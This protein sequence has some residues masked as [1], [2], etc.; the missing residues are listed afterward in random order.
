MSSVRTGFKTNGRF[1]ANFSPCRGQIHPNGPSRIS[2]SDRPTHPDGELPRRAHYPQ[3]VRC[4]SAEIPTLAVMQAITLPHFGDPDALAWTTTPDP[5]PGPGEVAV[6][7]AAAGINR[8]DLLQRQGRYPPPPGAS[9]ILGLECSGWV[10]EV[11]PG[12][13]GWSIGDEVCALLSGGGYAERVV[14]PAGQ[15][16]P[17]PSGLSL[18]EAASLP[19]AACTVWSTVFAAAQLAAGETFLV[20]GGTSGIG[21]FA[22]QLARARGVR[23]FTTAGTADKC[24]RAR[25]LGA[26]LAINYRDDDFVRR[27][28]EHTDGRGVDVILDMVGGDYLAR[29]LE[30]LAPDG[31]LVLI[32]TQRGRRA[33]LD[34]GALMRKRATVYGATLRA[35]PTAQKAAIVAQVR[36]HVWPL[37]EAGAI[38]PVIEATFPMP[39]AARAHERLEAG[40]H[41]GKVLLT[42]SGATTSPRGGE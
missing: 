20:H 12:V 15:L 41:V 22:I 33:E 38:R 34:L 19:E 25:A 4:A 7:V 16:L 14:V 9:E 42:T 26:E 6:Q 39:E 40:G 18:V 10:A 27:T 11:G 23:V 2:R 28:H 1:M 17:A 36:E 24:E 3:A 31:R 13:T 30:A 5:A 21:T 29:N 37:V 35:R 8:A 32:A